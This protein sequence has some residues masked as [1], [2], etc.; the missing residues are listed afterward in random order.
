MMRLKINMRA[1]WDQGMKLLVERDTYIECIEAAT[2]RFIDK[3]GGYPW[4][5]TAKA[6]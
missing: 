3:Y 6:A 4:K 1:E 2:Q 5:L